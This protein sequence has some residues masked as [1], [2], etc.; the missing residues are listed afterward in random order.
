[1]KWQEC[2]TD[3]ICPKQNEARDTSTCEWHENWMG[4]PNF[5]FRQIIMEM[6]IILTKSESYPD[7]F[8]CA[9]WAVKF[10][11][12]NPHEG[13]VPEESQTVINGRKK[14]TGRTRKQ[15]RQERR[16]NGICMWCP[17][18]TES[19]SLCPK[20]IEKREKRRETQL[21]VN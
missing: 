14:V 7:I 8:E 20:C 18:P 4:T 9:I 10:C 6:L 2:G 16:A 5:Q 19:K 3:L 15:L 21:A 13:D 1:M 11:K 17:N 12:D